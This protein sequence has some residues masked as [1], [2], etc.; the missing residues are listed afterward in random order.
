MVVVKDGQTSTIIIDN[1]HK[2]K[3][4]GRFQNLSENVVRDVLTTFNDSDP[5]FDAVSAH[6]SHGSDYFLIHWSFQWV[7]IL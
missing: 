4:T 6:F 1:G 7:E 3:L 5:L 2:Y